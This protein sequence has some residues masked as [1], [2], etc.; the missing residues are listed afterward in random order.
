MMIKSDSSERR[1]F[2][3]VNCPCKVILH[4]PERVLDT[5]T[6]N[7]SAGGIRVILNHEVKE[8]DLVGLEI[9][10]IAEPVKCEGRIVWVITHRGEFDTG[11]E[12]YEISDKDRFV[13]DE[14]IKRVVMEGNC[15]GK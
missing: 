3:R 1:K 9:Y 10:L 11:I 6:E 13:V 8:H 5:H 15:D 12:F 4:N 2:I 7:I 14:Y